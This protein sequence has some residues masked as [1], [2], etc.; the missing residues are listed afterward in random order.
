MEIP[1]LS[2]LPEKLNYLNGKQGSNREIQQRCQIH[3]NND[4]EALLC[5][6]N[7][8][9]HKLTTFRTYQKESERFLLWCVFQKQKPLSSIDRDDIEAYIQFLD[10]PQPRDKWCAKLGGRGCKRGDI[11]W[12]PFTH[13]LCESAKRTALSSIDSLFNYLVAARYLSFNPLS[14]IRRRNLK[15]FQSNLLNIESRI[16]ALDEWHAMVDTL[17]ELPEST[18]KE[19]NEKERLKFLI[20]ILYFL[21]LRINELVTHSWNSFRKVDENWWFYVIGKG[22]KVGRIP[23]NDELLRAIINY[24]AYLKKSP[25]PDMD[26]VS[27]LITSFTTGEAITARQINKILKKL[28]LKTTEKFS[29]EPNKIKKLR[30]FSAH[31]LRHL[32]ASMQD[33][34]GIAFKHIRENHR[35][36]NDATTRQYVHALDDERHEDMKKLKLINKRNE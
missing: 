18:I 36:E 22:D 24:R 27:P 21:G 35:H 19:K 32:S 29:N 10:D 3:A 34:A 9:R 33:R 5:W 15:K 4:Y 25:Y 16:L 30:K 14:L 8:Y 17:G 13:S 28:A 12:R 6:L 7:E 1:S 20:N 11:N 26:E 31:W 23:V 2:L